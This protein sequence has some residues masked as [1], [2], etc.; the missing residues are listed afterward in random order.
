MW[1]PFD[2]SQWQGRTDPDAGTRSQRWHQRITQPVHDV[3]GSC[4]V[5]FASDRGVLLN[6]GRT[7]AAEGP[8]VLRA[9]LANLTAHFD[10]PLYDD[11]TVQCAGDDLPASQA[12]FGD[13]VAARLEEGH[14]VIG[15]G[16]GH[17]IGYASYS[18]IRQWLDRHDP[19]ARLGILNFDAHFDLR[20]PAPDATSGTPFYQIAQDAK[21]RNQPFHYACIGISEA[22]NTPLLFDTANELGVRYLRDVDCIDL[23]ATPF[24]RRFIGEL[25][26]LYVTVC[27]DVFPAATAPGV[28]APAAIGIPPAFLLHCLTEVQ[29]C[30]QYAHCQWLM[31]DIAE[32]N[33]SYDQDNRTAKLAARLVWEMDALQS[34]GRVPV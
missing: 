25:D 13:R 9:A 1:Q 21:Q 31:G 15:L 27:L 2:Q 23:H 28:S 3:P 29:R 32:L 5:G 11:G 20:Q 6:K 4:L 8:P 7:G 24:I 17:E 14:F 26:Y 33:P 19:N 34:P 10:R 12:A 16:G 18:G 22:A 30:C